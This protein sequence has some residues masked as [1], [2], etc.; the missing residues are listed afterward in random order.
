LGIGQATAYV[1]NQYFGHDWD[2]NLI[3]PSVTQFNWVFFVAVWTINYSTMGVAAWLVK[4]TGTTPLSRRSLGWFW[5]QYMLC[6]LWIP[7]VHG[8]GWV[9]SAVL[10]DIVVGVP[11]FITGYWFCTPPAGHSG[12]LSPT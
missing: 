2:K 8:T 12:G 5:F 1:S 7:I 10:M 4:Q 6:L 9:G 11:A 3:K